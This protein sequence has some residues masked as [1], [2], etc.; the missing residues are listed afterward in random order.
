[1]N[2]GRIKPRHLYFVQFNTVK[3]CEFDRE[4][5]ALVLKK[6]SDKKTCI[7]M[8]LTT[9]DNGDGD[10]KINI[11]KISTL[12]SNLRTEDSYAV[13]NQVRTVNVER[14]RPLKEGNKFVESYIDDS[15][16]CKLLDLGTNELLYDLDFDEKINLHKQQYENACIAKM[17]NL[18]Y[19]LQKVARRLNK[20]IETDPESEEINSI[21]LKMRSIE[22]EILDILNI[23]ISYNLNKKQIDDG[24]QD[25]IDVLKQKN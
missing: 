2:F 3:L 6:N 4:H 16:F 5:L 18:A 24:L 10:N 9:E 14:F 19:T 8:P 25:I 15:L 13:Y 1:M 12:P 17:I 21:K 22:I 23:G 20:L 7:V 11:G